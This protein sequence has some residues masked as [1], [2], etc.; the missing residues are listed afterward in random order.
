MAQ[1]S[2]LTSGFSAIA[3]S[4][5]D[6]HLLVVTLNR[7]EAANAINTQMAL[8]LHALLAEIQIDAGGLRCI[9]LTGAGDRAFCAGADLKE[10]KG[11]D[12][13]AWHRQH[14]IFERAAYI[15]MDCHVPTIAAVNGAAYAGGCELALACDFAYAAE[16]ARFAL[17]ETSIGIIPGLGG[18]Q[19]LPRAIGLRRAKE[20]VLSAT[21]I[22]AMDA[23]AWGAVNR[24]FPRD[25]LMDETLAIARRIC[26]N[27]PVAVR[28]AKRAMDVGYS[29][30]I[31]TGL[32]VEIEA[33]NRT[34]PTEDRHEG[35]LAFNEKRKPVFKGR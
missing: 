33:Y 8:E 12:E 30:D 16:S 19:M 13:A 25:V 21:P 14:A 24:V 27:A 3:C 2:E 5:P 17:T 10:R 34:I 9:V 28:Q 31:K 35:I 23:L 29:V 11:M 6:E 20:V 1:L 32:A 7:P 15:L 4:W 26:A 22:S 18:T